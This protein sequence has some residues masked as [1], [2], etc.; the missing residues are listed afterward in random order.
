MTM[1]G[2][3]TKAPGHPLQDEDLTAIVAALRRYAMV[4]L[5]DAAEADDLV[6]DCLARALTYA[7]AGTRV[8]RWRPYLFTILHNLHLDRRA[9]TL[10]WG[11]LPLDSEQALQLPCAPNQHAHLELRELLAALAQLSDEQRDVILL[12]GLEGWSYKDVAEVLGVP[13]GT[14]MS[15]LSRGRQA[16]RALIE[17]PAQGGHPHALGVPDRAALQPGCRAGPKAAARRPAA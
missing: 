17:G 11:E 3:E 10:G 1:S 7:R 16:L 4:L 12:A 5:R 9:K 15:R 6:Q 13:I 14:V 8:R 2:R